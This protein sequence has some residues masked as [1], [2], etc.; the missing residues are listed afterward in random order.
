MRYPVVLSICGKQCYLDQEPDQIEL[1]TEGIL[2]QTQTGWILTY[3]ESS[4]TGLEGVTTTFHLSP[5][6]IVLNRTGRLRSQMVVRDG[7]SHDSLYEMEFGALMITVC[8]TR[9]AWQLSSQGG[10]VD[11]NYSIGIEQ[12]A[13][14]SI[15]YHLEVRG[16]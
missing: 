8:A 7:V 12:S 9:I 15:S 11:L 1:I 2:E 3:E 14:G 4:L 6:E 5:E 10:T 13:A 16:K